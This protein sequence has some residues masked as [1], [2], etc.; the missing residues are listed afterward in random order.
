MNEYAGLIGAIIGCGISMILTIVF[1]GHIS[2][3]S[4]ILSFSLL[5]TL[6]WSLPFVLAFMLCII[7]DI[8]I[9]DIK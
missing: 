3:I 6:I 5:V 1:V 7:F 9:F 2:N 8:K 4:S